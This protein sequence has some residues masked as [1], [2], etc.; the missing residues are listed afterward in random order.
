[1]Q[2]STINKPR[3]VRSEIK[4]NGVYLFLKIAP[5]CFRA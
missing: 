2:T 3:A 4:S 1:L 5:I